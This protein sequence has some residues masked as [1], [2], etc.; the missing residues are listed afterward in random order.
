MCASARIRLKMVGTGRRPDFL[1]ALK[2][3]FMRRLHK[4]IAEIGAFRS[5]FTAIFA[6]GASQCFS[7]FSAFHA[8]TPV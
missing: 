3:A 6:E 1:L 8:R 4:R 5:P 2:R 7:T